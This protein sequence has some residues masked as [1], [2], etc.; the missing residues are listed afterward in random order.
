MRTALLAVAGFALL[1]AP[2]HALSVETRISA[3]FEEKLKDDYGL[4]EA[5]ILKQA[6]AAKIERR[7]AAAPNV[8]RVVVTIEDAVPNRPT[9]GQLNDEPSLDL[10]RSFSIGGARVTGVAYDAAGRE[11][12]SLDYDW[13]ETD[14][15]QAI[16]STTWTDARWVFDRF[17]RKFAKELAS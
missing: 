16:G 10:V 3:A 11:I 5:D 2:A 9:F 17:A 12:G 1:G 14:I 4:R 8:D 6:L 13:Y 15:T 7:L